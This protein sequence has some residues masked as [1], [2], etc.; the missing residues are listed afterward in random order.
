MA[1]PLFFA[2]LLPSTIALAST[3]YLAED[4]GDPSFFGGEGVVLGGWKV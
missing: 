3:A 2:R 1:Q 4:S